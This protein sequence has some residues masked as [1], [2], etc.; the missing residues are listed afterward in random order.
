MKISALLLFLSFSVPAQNLYLPGSAYN[1]NEGM[2]QFMPSLAADVENLYRKEGIKDPRVFNSFLLRLQMIQGKYDSSLNTI[3]RL[4]KQW[5]DT[6]S[7][8][9]NVFPF[10]VYDLTMS[11]VKDRAQFP[12]AFRG[13]MAREYERL[14]D[15]FTE[16]AE[17]YFRADLD[18]RQANYIDWVKR[19]KTNGR[20]SISYNEAK[21]LCFAYA[22]YRVYGDELALAREVLREIL[23][24]RYIVEDSVLIKVRDG[25]KISATIVRK[26]NQP[27]QAAIL[28]FGI[29]ASA[30]EVSAAKSIAD[31]GYVGIVANT[32]G[33]RLSPNAIEPFEHDGDDAYD[34]IDWVSKQPWCNGKVAMNGGSYLGFV[35]WAA[36]KKIHPA[37]KTIVPQAAVGIG[38]DF[39]GL[40]GINWSYMLQWFHLVGNNKLQDNEGSNG[41][42][43]EKITTNWFKNGTAFNK[44]DSIEGTP[45]ATFQKFLKHPAFDSFWQKMIPFEKD[46]ANINIPVLTITGYYDDDQRGAFHYFDQHHKYN[47]KAEHYLVIGPFNH[48]GAQDPPQ[49]S[50]G[51]YSIDQVARINTTEVV[52]GWYDYILKGKPKPQLLQDKINYEVMGENQW[53]HVPSLGN[54]DN[55]S[56]TLYLSNDQNGQRLSASQSNGK[57]IIQI[58]DMK[59]RTHQNLLPAIN[60]E[61]N[62]LMDSLPK[63]AYVTFYSQ[64]FDQRFE[65]NGSFRAK[66]H[67]IVNKQDMDVAV[68]LYEQLSNGKYMQLSGNIA[69]V[70]QLKD[71]R[72]R[73]LLTPGKPETIDFKNTFFTSRLIDKGSR[74]VLI[75]GLNKSQLW[76]INCG[77]GKEVSKE[78]I[79]DCGEP[80]KIEWLIN[81]SQIKLPVKR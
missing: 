73:K 80:F 75:I 19:L 16:A 8:V 70:S 66:L 39:P 37:L 13:V 20:D 67:F 47:P 69:R 42:R 79:R 50:I 78:T 28:K 58:V 22:N 6:L 81:G 9:T 25:A 1:N 24:K 51:G 77:S 10:Y 38:I 52:F 54:M 26:R 34:I 59:D 35:Q 49:P 36:V 12:Q 62:I 53:K 65:I 23:I 48:Y 31:H 4:R 18:A 68:N 2:D 72:S 61:G 29:Y 45:N 5:E 17:G 64:P 71:L 7:R 30:S 21:S 74:L 60:G 55:D 44:L 76:E 40:M 33:K 15:R 57:P 46:F 32:R 56:L 43:W 41:Q 27:A 63:G 11:Q 3:A 14:P